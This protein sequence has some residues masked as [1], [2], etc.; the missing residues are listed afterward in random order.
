MAS[1]DG[2]CEVNPVFQ[3]QEGRCTYEVAESVMTYTRCGQVQT[4]PHSSTEKTKWAQSSTL[5]KK[6]FRLVAAARRK[7]GFL[8]WSYTR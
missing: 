7:I 2:V 1:G 3:T 6:L 8:L 4:R 5:T